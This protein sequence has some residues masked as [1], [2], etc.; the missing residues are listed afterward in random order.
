MWI[1]VYPN[2]KTN[3]NSRN[4]RKRSFSY[5]IKALLSFIPMKRMCLWYPIMKQ[6]VLLWEFM[7]VQIYRRML[8]LKSIER[9]VFLMKPKLQYYLSQRGEWIYGIQSWNERILLCESMIVQ[10]DKRTLILKIMERVVFL[11]KPKH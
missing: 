6:K 1:Q 2:G 8:I 7:F 3:S 9:L 4:S 11:M 10:I 5:Q